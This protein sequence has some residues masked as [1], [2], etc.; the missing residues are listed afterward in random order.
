MAKGQVQVYLSPRVFKKLRVEAVKRD[1]TLGSLIGEAGLAWCK[2]LDKAEMEDR[3]E[4]KD[5]KAVERLQREI[6]DTQAEL[7]QLLKDRKDFKHKT[8][9]P[10]EVDVNERTTS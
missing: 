7:D 4:H 3:K 1:T 6:D 5:L 10:K 2:W 9:K 8:N